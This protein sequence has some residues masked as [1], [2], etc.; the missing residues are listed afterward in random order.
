[1]ARRPRNT[2]PLAHLEPFDALTLV[3]EV[4]P[5]TPLEPTTGL[6]NERRLLL[7]REDEGPNGSFKWRGALCACSAFQAG[8]AQAVVTAST[9]NHGAAI[10]WAAARR[11]LS[12]HVVV[13]EGANPTKTSIIASHGAI[14]HERGPTLDEA[15]A[16]ARTLAHDLGAALFED[17]RCEAQLLGTAT[18]GQELVDSGEEIDVVIT[19]LACGALAGGLARAL[20]VLPN[21][22]WIIGVQSSSFAR[23]SALWH[24]KADPLQ[25]SGSSFADGLADNRIVEPSFSACRDYVDDV[26]DVSDDALSAAIRELYEAH[27]IVVEGAAAA[28]LAALRTA[29][30][31]VPPGC[32]VLITTGRNL[33]PT[34]EV[35]ILGRSVGD[36]ATLGGL[37]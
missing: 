10:A 3:R 15:S 16:Y 7:K 5:P 22:P 8:G 6:A 32:T 11:G 14:L 24:G 27:G 12:A 34:T 13:P 19:P 36:R 26:L 23:L 29:G 1:L 25:P 9:G 35:E 17:G 30:D 4:R 28:P 18:I 21:P 33:D 37:S 20:A 2:L 31:R